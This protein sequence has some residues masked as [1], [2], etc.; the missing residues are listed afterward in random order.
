[1][2]SDIVNK[3]AFIKST[4]ENEFK[5]IQKLKYSFPDMMRY[6][7]ETYKSFRISGSLIS[8][9]KTGKYDINKMLIRSG[10]VIKM[11]DLT[12]IYNKVKLLENHD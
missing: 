10:N 8:Y 7:T 3:I 12:N 9:Y 4:I 11:N 1:M 6:I 5:K 2:K